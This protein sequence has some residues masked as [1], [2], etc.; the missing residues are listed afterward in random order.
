MKKPSAPFAAQ[1]WRVGGMVGGGI[2]VSLGVVIE[3]A[4]QWAWASF[5]VAGIAA[6]I[7]ATAY[8]SSDRA[9]LRRRRRVRLSSSRSAGNLLRELSHG[10]CLLGTP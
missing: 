5:L 7:S 2:Y 1:R 4:G 8:G 9:L 3:A 6:W 10:C